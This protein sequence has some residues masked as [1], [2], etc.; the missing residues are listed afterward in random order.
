[1]RYLTRRHLSRRAVL[2]GAGATLALPLLAVDAAGRHAPRPRRRA[3]ASPA[4]TSRTA[5]IMSRWTPAGDGTAFELSP[6]LRSLEPLPR[7]AQ[8]RQRPHVAARVRRGRFGRREPHALVGRLAHVRAARDGRNAAARHLGRS[9]G[10]AQLRSGHAAAVARALA[11]GRRLERRLGALGRV[12]QHDRVAHAD[13][14]AADG[15]QSA[16]RV[17][18]AVRRRQHGRRSARSRRARSGEPARLGARRSGRALALAARRRPRAARAPPRGRARGRA[19]HRARRA[20][21]SATTSRCRR[22]PPACPRTSSST[23]SS[24]S[25]CSRSPGPRTSRASATLMIAKEVSNTVYPASGINDPFHNLSH[26][27]EVPANI[28]RY[29]RLNEYHT[30]TTLAYFLSRLQRHARTATA[31]CSTTRSCSTAAA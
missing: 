26:H 3:R 29:A 2:R 23:R 14:A 16:G 30:R 12:P 18:A 5:P 28:D 13:R 1:M 17:R 20:A 21:A 22:S 10:G 27:S 24:C 25:T 9:S 15:G 19:A 7:P 11:R 6:I 8:R 31:R 4:S